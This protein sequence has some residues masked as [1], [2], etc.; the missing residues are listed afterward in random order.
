V[1][2]VFFLLLAFLAL[3]SSFENPSKGAHALAGLAA[4]LAVT[5]KYNAVY[6]LPVAF[7]WHVASRMG[8]WR[9]KIWFY[10]G[11]G[12]G[13][14][15]GEPYAL[16]Y[17]RQFWESIEPYLQKGPLPE[18]AGPGVGALLSL[19]AKNMAFF[20]LGLPL[21]L[22]LLLVLTRWLV[23]CASRPFP[24]VSTSSMKDTVARYLQ[25]PKNQLRLM[26]ALT[27]VSFVVSMVLFATTIA[28]L[29]FASD[30]FSNL[31][32]S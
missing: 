25:A 23:G 8:G 12:L 17:R 27:V 16:V 10:P 21:M 29:Y 22:A 28:S 14:L 9:K 6:L 30:R 31:S 24:R 7:L 15:M 4:G 13:F 18:G 2:M 3:V 11:I 5:A 26:F 20:G 19:Q 1:T 32:N